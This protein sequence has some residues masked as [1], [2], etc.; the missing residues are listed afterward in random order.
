MDENK[1]LKHYAVLYTAIITLILL[2]PLF[3]YTKHLYTLQD[4]KSEIELK[5]IA[6]DIISEIEKFGFSNMVD[7]FIYPRYKNYKSGLFDTNKNP[8]FSLLDTKPKLNMQLGYSKQGLKRI[9]TIEFPHLRYFNARYLI[10]ESDFDYMPIL[11]DFLIVLFS[12]IV[13]SFLLSFIIL[14]SFAKPFSRINKALDGFIKD[15]MHEINTPLS[16]ININVDIFSEKFGINK[17]LSRIK[18]ASKMLST[19]YNDMD[20]LVKEQNMFYRQKENIDFSNIL[21]KSID[22]FQDIAELKAIKIEYEIQSDI[23]YP[24][25]QAKLQK[26]IDNNLSN[27][28]KYS[29][30]ESKVIIRLLKKEEY[31]LLEFEDFGIGI[32]S[33]EKIFSRFYRENHTKGG[34]GIGLNI[35]N[36]I[37]QEENIKVELKSEYGHGSIFSYKFPLN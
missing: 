2:L 13:I 17:Y 6:Y 21:M 22:Y 30:E 36:R 1:F 35:V 31:I 3:V 10:V 23:H 28:I 15:S 16:I 19:I 27:A 33:P 9:Y 12:I 14:K 34:F 5:N 8:V 37:T 25:V 32:K 24:F 26:I 29:K 18:S 20:Y 4:V 11:K 7:T